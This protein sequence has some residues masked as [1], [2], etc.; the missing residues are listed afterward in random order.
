[1]KSFG[2]SDYYISDMK[3]LGDD[4]IKLYYDMELCGKDETRKKRYLMFNTLH[5]V[6][7][8]KLS[9]M[10]EVYIMPVR[11]AIYN[12]MEIGLDELQNSHTPDS[13]VARIVRMADAHRNV[14]DF[15]ITQGSAL[16][17]RK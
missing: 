9:N 1:M 17:Y 14:V 15:N 13:G 7:Y 10:W 16:Y 3:A 2:L 8:T 11:K 12:N 4:I 5:N 6:G